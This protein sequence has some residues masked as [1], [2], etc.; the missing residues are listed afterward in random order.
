[1]SGWKLPG[2]VLE[3]LLGYGGSG[4]VW[5]A[6]VSSTGEPVA[7]KRIA[8]DDV[9]QVWTAQTEAALLATLEHP[10]L[11]RLHEMISTND[12]LVLVLELAAGGTLAELIGSRGRITPGEAITA[13]S[14]IG[15]ALAYAHNVGVV[16]GDVTPSNV[17]FT[18]A[19]MP[20]LADLGVARLLGDRGPAHSTPAFIDP[21][22]ASGCVPG[23]QSDVFMLGAVT[24]H[25]LTG[26]AVWRGDTP[27]QVLTSAAAA[28]TTEL[29]VLMAGLD[30]PPA[31]LA[32]LT[33]ALSVEPVQRGTAAEFALDLRHS[34]TPLPVELSAGRKRLAPSAPVSAPTG[35]AQ[36]RDAGGPVSRRSE[37]ERAGAVPTDPARPAFERPAGTAPP[38]QSSLLTHVVR[39][40][41]RPAPVSR[42][43]YGR[44]P[45][46]FGGA[47]L[48][49]LPMRWAA[50]AVGALALSAAAGIAWTT[51]SDDDSGEPAART[52]STVHAFNP[53][54]GLSLIPSVGTG[55]V[56]VRSPNPGASPSAADKSVI[57]LNSGAVMAVLDQLDAHRQQAF[58]D[59]NAALLGQVYVAGPLLAQDTALLERLVPAGCHLVG[60]HTTY[61]AVRI[62]SRHATTIDVAVSATLS[63]SLLTCNGTAKGR[64]PGSGP[65]T[66]NI[67]LVRH[68]VGYLIATIGR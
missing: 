21:A 16:H 27:A 29:D 48:G 8:L 1:M 9:A 40:R 58:D 7:L 50:V 54:T 20:L 28:D 43:R 42:A 17:L 46:R 36:R 37:I 55:T 2:F 67:G 11:V 25:A 24:L 44:R 31:M 26:R 45:Y 32:V 38:G 15:A 59:R 47:P 39:A 34:G 52:T 51:L 65:M 4:E 64:A 66:L 60:V 6:R 22:V 10:H 3:D 62:T 14:P 19:G 49:G 18:E 61:A 35:S 68:G 41:P 63:D 30:V 56:S 33:R 23:P 53:V 5:R 13:L 57:A 12:A